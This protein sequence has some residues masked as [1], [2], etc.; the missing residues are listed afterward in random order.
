MPLADQ[1]MGPE[2]DDAHTPSCGVMS[3]TFLSQAGQGAS[4]LGLVL[5]P[6]QL[7]GV[8][9]QLVPLARHVAVVLALELP[10]MAEPAPV[11]LP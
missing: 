1:L 4:L 3:E 5:S 9:A 6:E 10:P 8:A 11:F 2:A 7:E